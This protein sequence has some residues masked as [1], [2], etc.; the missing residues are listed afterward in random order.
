MTLKIHLWMILLIPY[1]L[2]DLAIHV[3]LCQCKICCLS[4]RTRSPYADLRQILPTQFATWYNSAAKCLQGASASN[5]GGHVLGANKIDEGIQA[6]SWT[7][8]LEDLD[9]DL[10]AIGHW[11]ADSCWSPFFW[12]VCSNTRGTVPWTKNGLFSKTSLECGIAAERK[13][14][15]LFLTSLWLP[16]VTDVPKWFYV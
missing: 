7:Y 3:P 14:C 12:S 1:F 11:V 16:L 4:H 13:N 5:D 15:G 2:N 6:R 9:Q 8:S 10:E